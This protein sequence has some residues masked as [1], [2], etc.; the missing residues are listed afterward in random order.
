MND[1][2]ALLKAAK[3]LDK[4]ALTAIF[5]MYAPV[6]YNY[7]LRLCQDPIQAD[8][9]VGDLFAKLVDQFANGQGPLTN[10]K[11]YLFRMAFH[12]VVDGA[13]Q[14][15][16]FAP[17][18]VAIDTPDK[19]KKGSVQAQIEERDLLEMFRVILNSELSDI[20]RHVIILRFMEGFSLRETAAIVDKKVNHVKVIQ[21]RGVAKLRKSLEKQHWTIG[22]S[23][24][25]FA[26]R[27]GD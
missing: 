7:V 18:E 9:I 16:Q 21:N 6:L 2:P 25:G 15:L 24:S 27:H 22:S 11:A 14:N 26:Q 12:S 20:Q 23:K 13:R 3:R 10:L 4:D 5:D 17:L 8:H 1:E 19:L